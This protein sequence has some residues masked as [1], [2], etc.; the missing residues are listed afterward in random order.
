[1]LNTIK[2]SPVDSNIFAVSGLN[3]VLFY[4]LR[5][6]TRLESIYFFIA[7]FKYKIIN[8]IISTSFTV[9]SIRFEAAQ[10]LKTLVLM[11]QELAFLV[12]NAMHLSSPSTICRLDSK[13]RL[14]IERCC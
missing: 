2:F 10:G 5:R 12:V 1:M 11:R 6:P 9:A 8:C 14:T 13:T 4:D 3:G 7:Y